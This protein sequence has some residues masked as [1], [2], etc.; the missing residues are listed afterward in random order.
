MLVPLK[1][2]NE[3]VNL[4]QIDL[5]QYE[6]AMIMSGSNTEGIHA[7]LDGVKDVVVGQ[8]KRIS[9]H[10]NADKLVVCQCQ[11]GQSEMRQIVTGA[12]NMK[13]GDY[14]AVALD[15][16]TI[17]GGKRI[18]SGE[19][20][21]EL[22]QGMM[23]SLQELGFNDKVIAKSMSDGLLVFDEPRP[24]GQPIGAALD[25]DDH[26]VEFEITP[27][28]PDCLSII[29]MAR[30]TAVTFQRD[31]QMPDTTIAAE[32]GNIAGRASVVIEAPD[33]CARY[34]CRIVEDV[35]IAQ[36]PLWLQ[37][38]LMKAGMRPINNIVDIT[39]YVLLE[40]GQPI[41]AFDL[42]CLAE[43]KIIVRN[44]K[45]GERIT[46]LD[47]VER[48]LSAEM[49][50]IG[51]AERAVALAGVMGGATSEVSDQTKRLLIEVANFDKTNIRETSKAL[52]LRS[53][54]SA[55][56]EKGISPEL[57]PAALDRVC[58]LIEKLGAG[59]IVGGLID[60]YPRPQQIPLIE[61]RVQRINDLIG[62]ALTA[63]QMQ[64]ILESLGCTVDRQG[65]VLR[66]QPPYFRLDL[67]KE[68]DLCEEIAR[69]YGYD[70]LPS[71]QPRDHAIGRLTAKQQFE[72]TVVQRLAGYGLSEIVTYSFIGPSLIAA[73]GDESKQVP[74]QQVIIRNPLGE[75]YSV[76]RP[77]LIPG[78]LQVVARNLN[79][80]IDAVSLFEIGNVFT[81]AAQSDAE[82][83][84]RKRLIVALAADDSD[85]FDLKR[86]V[87]SLLASFRL[88]G[89]VYKADASCATYHPGRAAK[90][91]LDTVELGRIG[92]IHPTVQAAFAVPKPVYLAEIDLAELYR[93]YDA[94][95]IYRQLPKFP[96]AT[97]D[98]AYVVAR[99]VTH[100]EMVELI[101][102]NGGA[103]LVDVAL[104]DVYTGDQ[105][106]ADKKSLAY[107]LTFRA[108]DRTLVDDDIKQSFAQ[109][110]Q[111]LATQLAAELRSADA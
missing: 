88:D 41:H 102:A 5:K 20:R 92:Q 17:A 50:V 10:P 8:I 45:P 111:A 16:A 23:C 98:A 24:L 27:N 3:Y 1:W 107:R 49:L 81:A 77:S 110:N 86:I 52:G 64:Q 19:L 15:G 62:I 70:K 14:V 60:D 97:M 61:L 79:R 96:A 7:L 43:G 101:R 99:S 87:D 2:L 13:E 91:I 76:M 38:R 67:V 4:D 36:S 65:A 105:I 33:K 34:A 89:V 56:F 71:T 11:I 106:A 82:P 103:H 6:S 83:T 25:L 51:D 104:F 58:H 9:P 59:K 47:Q 35:V 53:E 12:T 32:Q 66:V 44:A 108:D 48:K 30:E 75:E 69:V 93:Q 28:R 46:T 72:R 80:Q 100:Q 42:D 95:V 73:L 26:V 22:S 84:E 57:V 78:M 85:Y 37:M 109:I 31:Y 18:K 29:G 90:L 63:E 68:I 39:N 40:Y 21:G 55:R 74:A 54:A 94:T